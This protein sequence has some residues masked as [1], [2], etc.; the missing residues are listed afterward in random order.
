MKRHPLAIAVGLGTLLMLAGCDDDN[1]SNTAVDTPQPTPQPQTTMSVTAID[2][3]LNKATVWLDLDKDYQ[4]DAN[5]PNVKSGEKGFAELDVSGIENPE[6]YP[7]VVKAIIGE[8]IDED[9]PGVT[10]NKDFIM[11][12]PAGSDVVSPLT[13]MV[14][15]K[16]R[17]EGIPAEQAVTEVASMLGID[18]DL[19]SGDYGDNN[20]QINTV[21]VKLVQQSAKSIVSAGILPNSENVLSEDNIANT[22]ADVLAKGDEVGTVLK[23]DRGDEVSDDYDFERIVSESIVVDS[24]SDKDGVADS[25]DKFPNESTEWADA[26]GDTYGDNLA[27]KF[28]ED[29]TEWADTDGDNYGD[30]IADKFP[31]DATEWADTDGDN[32]GDNIADKFPED[33]TEWADS[34]GDNYGDNFADKFPEDSTEWFDSDNDNVGD[35]SDDYPDNAEKSVADITNTAHKTGPVMIHWLSDVREVNTSTVTVVEAFNNGDIRTS[36]SMTYT[37]AGSNRY[38]GK[39][40]EVDVLHPN[41]DFSRSLVWEYDFNQD[42]LVSF[43]GKALDR[44]R[45]TLQGETFWRYSDEASAQPEGGDNGEAPRYFDDLDLAAQID[46]RDLTGV[47]IIQSITVTSEMVDTTETITKSVKQYPLNGFDFE[48][49]E[50]LPDYQYQTVA[51][52]NSGLLAS[53][54]EWRDWSA[55]GT[56][57]ASF[58]LTVNEGLDYTFAY[59]RPIWANPHGTDFEEYSQYTY[60]QGKNGELGPQWYELN[61]QVNWQDGL[62]TVVQSGKRY[63]LDETEGRHRKRTNDANPDGMLFSRYQTEI[64]EVSAAETVE[65][66]RWAMF[67]IDDSYFGQDRE[68]FTVLANDMGQDY[69]IFQRLDNGIWL[70]H[71]FAEWGSQN[72]VDLA[73]QVEDLRAQNYELAQITSAEL[74]SLS[75]YDGKILTSSFRIDENGQ[76]VTWHFITNNSVITGNEDGRYQLLDITLTDNGM[77]EGW[78]V[79]DNG[80]GSVVISVPFTDKPWDWYNAYWRMMVEIDTFNT[81]EGNTY[82]WTSWLGEFYLDQAQA[83]ARAIELGIGVKEYAVCTE[84]DTGWDEVNDVP[85]GS[86]SYQDFVASATN[87]Q[88][89]TVA[90]SDIGGAEFYRMNSR[91]EL[92]HWVFNTDGTGRY[93]R[94]GYPDDLFTWEINSDGI[95]AIDYGN[96]ALDYFAYVSKDNTRISFKLYSEWTEEGQDLKDIWSSGFTFNRPEDFTVRSCKVNLSSATMDDFTNAIQSCGGHYVVTE[97]DAAEIVNTKFVRVRGAGD[98]RAYRFN[99]DNS[100]DYYRA[101]ESRVDDTRSWER[102]DEGYLKVIWDS[103]NP[104]EYMLLANLLYSD[105]QSSFIIYDVYQEDGQWIK[106]VWSIVF[107]EYEGKEITEC[108]EGNSPWNSELDQPA[109]YNRIADYYEAVDNCRVRTDDQV[110]TFTEDMLVGNNDK[111]STWALLYTEGTDEQGAPVYV[112][113]ERIRFDPNNKGAFVDAEDGEFGFDWQIDDGRLLLSITHQDYVGSTENLSIV[114]S[115]GEYFSVKTFWIDTSGEWANPAPAEG[116]GEVSSLLFKQVSKE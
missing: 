34:D 49:E 64:R 85:A 84:G 71:R 43:K 15:M 112:E 24:D 111:S 8:T 6:Q 3:Y 12:A 36:E 82:S 1:S 106:D 92:R 94:N 11:S 47:D 60:V 103:S 23:S 5:E 45:R 7:I 105:D 30:N 26:D 42:G 93:F 17:S 44:G 72:I 99:N 108:N 114:E 10:V 77:K 97:E 68:N 67:A 33:A 87:C 79:N 102:T 104:A 83:N 46:A 74:P 107:R 14:D 73:G 75:N 21:A 31:E 81:I 80:S 86:P 50:Y 48:A 28:P 18:A 9:N 63:L 59:Q 40:A 13:T 56:A 98:T 58:Q 62:K 65:T 115:D 25:D 20:P 54:E 38:F 76:P 35:N 55:D 22:L 16:I 57:N 70:G 101:G 27:D 90:I 95:V 88:Y 32:Y 19:I 39:E 61:R 29:A 69:K 116:E 89:E 91:G 113:E 110:L 37:M 2:G 66:S 109:A 41:G 4:L 100:V 53:Y 51:T 78:L 52:Y 96:N